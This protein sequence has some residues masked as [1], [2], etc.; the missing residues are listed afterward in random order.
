MRDQIAGASSLLDVIRNE[1]SHHDVRIESEHHPVLND[2]S[3][4]AAFVRAT[5]RAALGAEVTGCLSRAA[6]AALRAFFNAA[7]VT[8]G[9]RTPGCDVGAQLMVYTSDSVQTVRGVPGR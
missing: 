7:A 8:L 6:P 2:S 1:Q 5:C 4:R 9:I 3:V